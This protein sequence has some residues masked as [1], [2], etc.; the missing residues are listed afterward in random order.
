MIL[1]H[2]EQEGKKKKAFE[3]RMFHYF[4]GIY[5]RLR[6]PVFPV[7]MFTDPHVWR[8]PVEKTYKITLFGCPVS[9]YT[10]NVIRLKD[11]SAAEFEEKAAENPLAAAYLPLTDY[12]EEDRPVIKAKAMKGI[13]KVQDGRKRA[14][15]YSL[16]QESVRLNREEEKRF[17]ELVKTDPVYQEVKMFES[18]EEVRLEEEFEKGGMVKE[19]LS[20][21]QILGLK[22][23]SD[24]EDLRWMSAGQLEDIL[25]EYRARKPLE[26]FEEAVIG[27]GK[28]IGEIQMSQRILRQAV[29]SEQELK[30]KPLDELKEILAELESRLSAITF[31]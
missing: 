23:F 15:L 19:I 4:C 30:K 13:A 21:E 18:V 16:I 14:A 1:I 25:E 7:A 10:Y 12:P 5:F 22:L 31:H 26:F 27:K 9:E 6:K 28:L 11:Y 2:W 29:A 24:E 17:R 8:K 20:S 3:E